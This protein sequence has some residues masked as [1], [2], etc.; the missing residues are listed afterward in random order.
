ME[1]SNES[2]DTV[3]LFV[4]IVL[5]IDEERLKEIRSFSKVS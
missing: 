3:L 2:I 4:G 5:L 1:Q